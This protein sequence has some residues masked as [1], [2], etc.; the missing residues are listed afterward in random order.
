MGD[1]R[2]V[3]VWLA[4]KGSALV[5]PLTF[6]F[7]NTLNLLFFYCGLA[8]E[9]NSVRDM[10]FITLN[11]LF[12][13]FCGLVFLAV[14]H[15]KQPSIP[16]VMV[17]GIGIIF[18]IASLLI[19]YFKF[20]LTA[21]LLKTAPIFVVFCIPAFFAGYCGATNEKE[22]SFFCILEN[23]SFLAFPAA[24]IYH[25]GQLF[26]L[27]PDEWNGGANLGILNYMN[28]AY[29]FMP[30]MLTHMIQ[31][32][33][34]SEWHL[35]AGSKRITH[36]QW[37]RCF[38]AIVYWLAIIGS[39]TRGAYFSVVGVCLFLLLGLRKSEAN[40]RKNYLLPIVIVAILLL[41]M[42]VYVPV[43]MDRVNRMDNIVDG[44]FN[45]HGFHMTDSLFEALESGKIT[46]K[47]VMK[48][49]SVG[50]R[51]LLYRIAWGEFLRCPISGIGPLGYTIKHGMYPHNAILELLCETGITG[52]VFLSLIAYIFVRLLW[53]GKNTKKI[54]YILAFILAYCIQANISGSLWDC[55]PLQWA[56]GYG[57]AVLQRGR[58]DKE[59]VK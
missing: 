18:V 48:E 7:S 13:I 14:L 32:V 17:S 11:I 41:Y 43:G 12:A 30:F 33:K 45:V 57:L 58:F 24:V 35:P 27:L 51:G 9:N 4:G 6:V 53:M 29:T 37:L 46:T 20:G 22:G 2:R 59:I 50:S 23:V 42:F 15:E 16:A 54:W 10:G 47:E 3:A 28:L 25:F 49:Y 19:S 55:S 36:P 39:G 26:Q 38:M 44:Y 34:N 1:N 52:A 5:F 40:R 8:F 21:A 56:I 31:F